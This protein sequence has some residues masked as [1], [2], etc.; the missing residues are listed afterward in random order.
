MR[1]QDQV[2]IVTGGGGS[3]GSAIAKRMHENGAKVAISDLNAKGAADAAGRIS[4]EGDVASFAHDVTSPESWRTLVD[5]VSERFGKVDVL[6][7]NAG[8]GANQGQPFESISYEEW[9]RVMAVNLDGT[10]LGIGAVTQ[11]MRD[12]GGGAIVNIASVAGFIGTMGGAAYGTSKGAV[13]TLTKQAAYSFAIHGYNIRVNAIHPGY[14]WTEL[15]RA[16]A[17]EQ[18]GSEGKALEALSAIAPTGRIAEP[19]DVA[20]AAVYLASTESKH[21]TGA[22]IVVDGGQLCKP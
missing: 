12:A 1:L 2:A 3:I 9:K 19:D 5:Q 15:I 20:W 18:Y 21:V 13:T 22:E 16:R 7:N 11:A 14:C 10:F 4:P 6:V 17:L 8:V